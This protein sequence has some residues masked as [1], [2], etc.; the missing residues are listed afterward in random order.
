MTQAPGRPTTDPQLL[1]IKARLAKV[2]RIMTAGRLWPLTKGNVSARVPGTDRVFILGHIHAEGRTLDTTDV[3]DIVTIDLEGNMIE[4]R[5]EPVEERFLHTAVLKAR[6]DVHSVVHCHATYATAF[7]IAGANILPV[8]NRGAIFAPMVPIIEFDGL[9]DTP[10]R[11][12]MV[13]KAIGDGYALVLKNHG[14][15]AVGD[16]VENACIVTLALEETAQLQWIAT[17][18]GTPQKISTGQVRSV[19]TGRRKEEY[20]S[21]VWGHYEAMDPRGKDSM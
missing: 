14:V 15:V 18:L 13:V 3:D 4:G 9:I 6:P 11:G 16:T 19:L 20:F 8:G 12:E 5:I 2:H 10:E 7:G 1:A 21:H 17:A